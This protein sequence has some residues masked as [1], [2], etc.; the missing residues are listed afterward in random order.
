M[1]IAAL[2][3]QIHS[4][5]ASL[6]PNVSCELVRFFP[7]IVDKY[8]ETEYGN[9]PRNNQTQHLHINI[10]LSDAKKCIFSF[11]T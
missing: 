3:V 1:F 4:D 5:S 8:T 6:Q 10:L 11:L 9:K 2:V 7:N